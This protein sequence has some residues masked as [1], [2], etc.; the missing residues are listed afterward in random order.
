MSVKG[1][2]PKAAINIIYSLLLKIGNFGNSLQWSNKK[3]V[4]EL[5]ST[6]KEKANWKS[7]WKIS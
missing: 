6:K 5:M 3:L 1:H 4:V 2:L 7:D